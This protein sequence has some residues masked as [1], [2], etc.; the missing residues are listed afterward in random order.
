MKYELKRFTN[1]ECA[2]ARAAWEAIAGHDAFY[3]E[4]APFFS[5]VETHIEP[6]EHDSMALQL[7]NLGA[8]GRVD[9]IVE[10]VDSRKGTLSKLLK[11]VVSPQFWD[12]ND[13]RNSIVVIYSEIFTQFIIGFGTDLSRRN[14]KIYG[15]D[16]DMMS[17]LRSVHAH[18]SVP[19]ATADFEGRFL[20]ISF[21][22][23]S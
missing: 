16:D 5:W 11:I 1:A 2:E 10:V 3:L 8:D 18:W 6:Q 17:I 13:S 22:A 12:V 14:V 20:A 15:R 7:V 19:G 23:R 21:S 4:F 9:A